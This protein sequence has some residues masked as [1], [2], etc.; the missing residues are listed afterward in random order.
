MQC[1][2]VTGKFYHGKQVIRFRPQEVAT[3]RFRSRAVLGCCQGGVHLTKRDMITGGLTVGFMEVCGSR[4]ATASESEFTTMEALKGK[5]YGKSRMQYKDYQ[6]TE[7]GLQFQDLVIGQ[8]GQVGTGEKVLIDWDGYTIGYY[9]R[10]FEARNKPKGGTFVG[11]DKNYF[12]FTVG[13]PFIIPAVNEGIMGMN[14]GGIRRLIVPEEIGYPKGDYNKYKPSP[15]TFGGKRTLD[16]VLNNAGMI[17]KTLL[18]DIEIIRIL[19]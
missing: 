9:G 17:D 7:S 8:G 18:I 19:S 11:D 6:S 4:V 1:C 12:S 10:P 2:Q 5:N 3:K 16:F 13:D 14:A 15:T